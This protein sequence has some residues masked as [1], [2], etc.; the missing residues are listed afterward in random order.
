MKHGHLT[1]GTVAATGGQST[2]NLLLRPM[3]A[4]RLNL[5][6]EGIGLGVCLLVLEMCLGHRD[7]IKNVRIFFSPHLFGHGP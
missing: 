4:E 1:S 7:D 6:Q 5:N 2:N 3:F